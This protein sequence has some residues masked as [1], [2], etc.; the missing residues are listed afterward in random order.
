VNGDGV[1]DEHD[2]KYIGDPNPDFTFGINN[3]ITW[4]DFELSF[5]FNGSVGNDVYNFVREHHTDPMGWG[6]KM[7]DVADY[8]RVEMRD[9]NGSITDLSNVYLANPRTAKVQRITGNGQNMNDNNRVSSRFVEDGSYIRLKT[10]SLA[11]NLPKAWLKPLKLD[12]VQVY[13]N[14]QNLFTITSYKG[15]DPELGSISQNVKLQGLDNYR[16]PSQRIFNFG[17]KVS[18]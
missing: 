6:N 14:V 11:W 18:L 12:W 4:K 2:R 5:F 15:F 13:G 10:L 9:P 7:A 3:V 8:A 17:L 1:I 16:Y